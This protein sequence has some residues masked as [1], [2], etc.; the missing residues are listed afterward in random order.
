[1][2]ARDDRECFVLVQTQRKLTVA[3][4]NRGP[5][6]GMSSVASVKKLRAQVVDESWVMTRQVQVQSAHA[7]AGLLVNTYAESLFVLGWIE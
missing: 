2:G 7:H 3:W 6:R 5:V 1:M 4:T